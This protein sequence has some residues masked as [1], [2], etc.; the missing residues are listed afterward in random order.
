MENSGTV[1]QIGQIQQIEQIGQ[2]EQIEQIGQIEQ[3]EQ[4]EQMEQIEEEQG[5]STRAGHHLITL[6]RTPL[7]A[8]LSL[9]L[10][11]HL[12]SHERGHDRFVFPPSNHSAVMKIQKSNIWSTMD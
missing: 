11:L 8:R 3:I 7:W 1:E 5:P 9:L 12:P 6:D 10:P 4:I 2:I